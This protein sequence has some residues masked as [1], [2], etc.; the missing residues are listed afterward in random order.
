[1]TGVG[2]EKGLPISSGEQSRTIS[3]NEIS[4][5]GEQI[6]SHQESFRISESDDIKS[7]SLYLR[8]DDMEKRNTKSLVF[9]RKPLYLSA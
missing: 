9:R 1:L 7:A 6:G 8:H 5:P 3:Y 4:S 2:G